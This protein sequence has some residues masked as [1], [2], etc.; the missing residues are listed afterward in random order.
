MNTE[1]LY[2]TM[3]LES[4]NTKLDMTKVPE[5]S[6]LHQMG[7]MSTSM[8]GGHNFQMHKLDGAGYMIR[9]DK[10]GAREFHHVD[11]NLTGGHL[12]GSQPSGR[13]MSTYHSEIR[14][15]VESGVPVRI[16]A[17]HKLA[18]A[19]HSLTRRM[20]G[21]NPGYHATDPVETQHELTGDRTKTWMIHKNA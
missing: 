7:S 9:F 11:D 5:D 17:H 4:M 21:R 12:T 10:A 20:I 18:D 8:I 15:T 3:V 19:F 6:M 13:L 14:N 16:V 1:Q 2:R